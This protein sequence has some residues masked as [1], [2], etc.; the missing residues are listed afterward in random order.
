MIHIYEK[1]NKT[2]DNPYGMIEVTED[3]SI[4]DGPCVIVMLAV[5]QRLGDVNGSMR[6]V[7]ELINPEIDSNY[8]QSRRIF[9]VSYGDLIEGMD[10]FRFPIMRRGDFE[11]VDKFLIPLLY[12]DGNLIEPLEAMKRF[13]NLTFVT[14]C[15][16]TQTFLNFEDNL[17]EKMIELG[18][19]T[20]DVNLILS[21]ICLAGISGGPLYRQSTSTTAYAFGDVMDID[22]INDRNVVPGVTDGEKFVNMG[23]SIGYAV[24]NGLEH[25]FKELMTSDEDLS[26]HIKCFLETSLNNANENKTNEVINPITYE[27]IAIA[28]EDMSKGKSL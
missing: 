27:K 5:A 4:F 26:S 9:G 21:Q 12:E 22:F 18:Y 20:P 14:F 28:F 23:S 1:T 13:R 3:K 15:N 16:A 25:D 10:K 8:D 2:E 17:R 7:A 24:N 11:F 6:Q 19:S